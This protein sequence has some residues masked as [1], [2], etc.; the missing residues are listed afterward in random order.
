MRAACRES[1]AR[2]VV[3]PR[4]LCP[5][6]PSS[7]FNTCMKVVFCFLLFA[8]CAFAQMNIIEPKPY[9]HITPDRTYHVVHYKL[10]ITVDVRGKTCGGTSNITLV[11][12]RPNLDTVRI[13]AGDMKISG[14]TMGKSALQYRTQ[15]ETLLVALAKPGR[16]TDTMTLAIAY[17][18]SSP[19]K[20]M[21]F[22]SPDSGYPERQWQA[23]TQGECEDNHFW[24]P[25]YDYLTDKFTSEMIATVDDKFVAISNGLLIDTKA[26]PKHHT[27]T[28]HWKESKPHSS[29][30]VSLIVGNY[31]G[32]KDSWKNISVTSYVYPFQKDIAKYSF[33]KTPKMIGLF[34]DKIGVS[35]PWEKFAQ[36]VVQDFIFGGEENVTAVT[37]NDGT[38]HDARADLDRNSDGLVSHELAHMWWGDL[39]TCRSWRH[40][41]LNEGFATYF[42][43]LFTQY[44]KGQDDYLKEVQNN[45]NSIL[46]TD[47]G[48]HR[49]ATVSSTYNEP[50]ELFGNRIYDKGGVILHMLRTYLGEELFWK[51]INHYATKFSYQNVE[52]NDFKVA[53]EEA[54]GE[55]LDWFF[56]QWVY[57]PGYPEFTVAERYDA[58][59][60]LVHLTVQ[61]VQKRDSLTGLFICPLDVQVWV[62]DKPEIHRI[63][64][65]KDSEEFT[66]SADEK[67]AL[68][69]FDK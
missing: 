11:P 63:T 66:F 60:K 68:V 65:S 18:V 26:D 5:P 15:D 56:N 13:G 23:W 25:C 12:L 19:K 14:V 4:F 58:D 51:S 33:G 59:T 2:K 3:A 36:T 46:T 50:I 54:T 27:K 29:Y 62:H 44:D 55:N 22:T 30:L 32:V 45:Q 17:S 39:L 61:Q 41:W 31:V 24:F 16:L 52:T 7:G 40:A 64:C 43:M 47:N 49:R 48:E 38:I 67:P 6:V 20:G 37:L 69:I 8:Y 21:Y 28:Y 42:E 34:S 10:N 1:R 35:Y 9:E 53:I 57:K